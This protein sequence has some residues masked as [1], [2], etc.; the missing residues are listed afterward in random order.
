LELVQATNAKDIERFMRPIHER[1]LDWSRDSP[2]PGTK[3]ELRTRMSALR[4]IDRGLRVI[5]RDPL[6][7]RIYGDVAV[8]FYR[9][10]DTRTGTASPSISTVRSMHAWKRIGNGWQLLGGMSATEAIASQ[11]W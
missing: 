5:T 7:V 2:Q 6:L 3:E 4:D 8:D 10:T 9:E 1:F 11:R